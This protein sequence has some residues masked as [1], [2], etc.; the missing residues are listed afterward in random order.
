[1]DFDFSDDQEQLRDAVR[2]W[3]DKGYDFERRRAIV[4]AGGFDRAAYGELAELGLTGLYITEDDGG[5]GMGPVEGMVVMEE[6]GRGIVLEP[7][8]QT[9]IAGAVL[10]GYASAGLKADWLPKIASGEAVVV[11][12]HQERGARY[13]LDACKTTAEGSGDDCRLTGAKSIVPVGDRADAFLVPAMAGGQMGLYLVERSAAGVSARGYL[14]QDGSR[15]AELVLQQTPARLVTADGLAALEHAVDIGIAATCAEAV[16]VMDKTLAI[17]VDYM[18]TRKQFGVAIASFQALRHRVADMKMQLEL[19]RSMS[20]Y[21]SLKLNAPAPERRRALARA[22]VQLG[23]SMRF[24]GQQ[25]VQL[26]GGIGVTDEYIVSHYFK[27]LT[28]M[29]MVFGDTLHHLGE[30]SARM[31]DTAGV[32]A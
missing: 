23:Q 15:S 11:L 20:Y 6:L 4:A 7:L 24:V 28:Q 2:K 19:A 18:N 3:V 8:A 17:T 32:F 16:G 14:T 30:V 9:L 1:M 13:R 10:G 29:E 12:A 21:A 22:K 26:H 31:E 5:L 27:K 25:A